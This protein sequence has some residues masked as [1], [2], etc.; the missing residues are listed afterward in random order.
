MDNNLSDESSPVEGRTPSITLQSCRD[1]E[2]SE[3]ISVHIERKPHELPPKE[4]LIP[5]GHIYYGMGCYICI[6][7]KDDLY[8]YW[9]LGGPNGYHALNN[10]NIFKEDITYPLYTWDILL[11]TIN[12]K[13]TIVKIMHEEHIY[14]DQ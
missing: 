12:E 1:V 4:G 11:S 10:E 2:K 5:I 3:D 13:Y 14:H 8:T 6:Y 9:E 7:Q